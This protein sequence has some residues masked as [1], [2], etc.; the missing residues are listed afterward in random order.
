MTCRSRFWLGRLCSLTAV[1]LR[2]VVNYDTTTTVRNVTDV[3]NKPMAGHALA[4]HTMSMEATFVREIETPFPDQTKVLFHV[5][6]AMIHW[7]NLATDRMEMT[8]YVVVSA[9]NIERI[10]ETVI[11]PSNRRG[12]LLGNDPFRE[13]RGLYDIADAMRRAGFTI[14]I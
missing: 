2:R 14:M 1:F 11:Y 13:Y 10:K 7:D 4:R 9:V 3:T 12:D 8:E 5:T 6:K